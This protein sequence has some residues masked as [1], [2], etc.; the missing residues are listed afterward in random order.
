MR[1]IPKRFIFA[2][3][4]RQTMDWIIRKGSENDINDIAQFQVEMASESEG[5]ILDLPTVIEGVTLAVAD[6]AKGTYMLACTPDGKVAGSL[7]LTREWSDWRAKW[8]WW[9]QSVYVRPE[10]RRQGA[11]RALYKYVKNLAIENS[12]SCLR[13]YVDRENVR[14]QKTY[15]AQ[16]MSE[17]HYL[18]YEEDI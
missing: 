13:L 12:I 3:K 18:L 5:T 10:Y 7:F 2:P 11:Y 17:S 1:L 6:E 14:A 8:Y 9:I 15:Q 16:G 4:F